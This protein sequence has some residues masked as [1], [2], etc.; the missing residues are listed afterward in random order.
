[1]SSIP[2]LKNKERG[3]KWI[4]FIYLQLR[5]LF[6]Q[7][8][9]HILGQGLRKERQMSKIS[10]IQNKTPASTTTVTVLIGCALWHTCTSMTTSHMA[11]HVLCSL[12]SSNAKA[13]KIMFLVK[14][15]HVVTQCMLYCNINKGFPLFREG[16]SWYRG[17]IFYFYD[18][19]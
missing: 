6:Q 16:W 13:D 15:V 11:L 14:S 4:S 3:I 10:S 2:I 8:P 19:C 18:S 5:R 12:C 1:M 7:K 9:M 17:M